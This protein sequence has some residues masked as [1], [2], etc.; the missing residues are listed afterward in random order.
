MKIIFQNIKALI[1]KHYT[2]LTIMSSI[3]LAYM[4]YCIISSNMLELPLDC[5]SFFDI[6]LGIVFDTS[7]IYFFACLLSCGNTKSATAITFFITSIWAI[8]NIIYSHFFNNY[9]TLSAI[10]QS[11]SIL[12]PLVIKSTINSVEYKYLFFIILP[13]IFFLLYRR[14]IFPPLKKTI[15][16]ICLALLLILLCDMASHAVF[17]LSEPGFRYLSYYLF[18]LNSRHV[19]DHNALCEPLF[20]TLHRGNIRML[21]SESIDEIQGT[22]ELTNSQKKII[23]DLIKRSKDSMITTSKL[24]VHNIIFIIVESYMSFTSQMKINGKE[25]TPFLNSLSRDTTIYYNGHVT[26]NITLGESS[27]G[28]FIYMTGLLP[29]RSTITISRVRDKVLPGLP[30]IISA[31]NKRSRMIIPTRPTLWNQSAMC[32]R[33]GFEQLFSSEDYGDSH[34]QELNDQ[35]VFEL[36]S[37]IDCKHK[38]QSFFSVI[39]TV[40]MHQPYIEPKDYSFK[41]KDETISNELK[42]YLNA[43]HYTDKCIHEYINHLKK[44]NLYDNSLIIITADHHVHSTNF[45]IDITNELPLYIINGN[46]DNHIAW[47]GKCNQLDIYT[48]LLDLLNIETKWYGLGI[49][50]LSPHYENS[51]NNMKWDVSDQII[52][53]DFFKNF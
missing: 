21:A 45:G 48:T 42:N 5:T 50:L 7:I 53:S 46:I 29:T 39:L 28:Q 44:N 32:Q 18:R 40:S 41:I 24:N 14:M 51:L 19:S 34:R 22:K 26:P 10:K 13:T 35:E 37:R 31:L 6:L 47:H 23:Y 33:Y 4:H 30:K 36:A 16:S 49:S 11:S 52:Q 1:S 43:C 25:I 3:N 2:L 17:C 8:I 9:L 15:S 20:T 27:D 38:H 12:D